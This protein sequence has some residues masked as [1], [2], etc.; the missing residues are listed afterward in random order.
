MNNIKAHIIFD[1]TPKSIKIKNFLTKKFNSH[2]LNEANLV[3]VVGGD[4]FMLQTLKRYRKLKKD[5]L[6]C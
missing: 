3:I 5:I 6:W 4:G 2:R 1:K